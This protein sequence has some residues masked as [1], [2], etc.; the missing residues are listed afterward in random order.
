MEADKRW[1]V[2]ISYASPDRM[3]VEKLALR[4]EE[5]AH[6]RVFLDKWRLVPGERFIPGLQEAIFD[7]RSCAVFL[8]AAGVRPWQNLEMEAA[9]SRAVNNAR[10]GNTEFRIV[11]VLLPGARELN[12][13]ELPPF[14]GLRTWVDFRCP[15]GLDDPDAFARLVSGVRGEAPG[16][17]RLP[18]SWLA[19]LGIPELRRPTGIASDGGALFVADHASG[20]VMRIEDGAIVRRQ[21]G[22]QKPHHLIVMSDVVLVADTHHH[23]LASYDLDL[24]PLERRSSFG[25]YRLRRP[26]GLASNYPGEFYLADSDNHRIL[27]VRDGAVTAVAGRAD[28]CSGIDVGEFSVPCGLGASLDC[29]Y[30]ADTYNHR[31]QVLTRDL[32]FISSFGSMGHGMGEFAYPVAVASWQQWIVVADEHNKRL[33]LWRREGEELPFSATCVRT[34][35]CGDWLGS[36]F[37]LFFDED[38]RLWVADRKNGQV[39]RLDLAEMI[40][41]LPGPAE[42]EPPHG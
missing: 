27:L 33:Q 18:P 28:C 23:E 42:T 39:L 34:D 24:N 11:P 21:G 30:V 7:S 31:V 16:K 36:P 40:G 6:L 41:N 37:G 22:L 12:E 5:E 29:V 19:T 17:P 25:T 20:Q 13:D 15:K 9:L 3:E 2:F 8:G 10:Q 1:D 26:H 14:I 35:L 38:G 4:L 32:R